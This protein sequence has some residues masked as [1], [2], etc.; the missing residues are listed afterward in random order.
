ML[1]SQKERDHYEEWVD[2]IKMKVR[3]IEWSG[4]LWLRIWKSGGLL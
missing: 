4:M 3:A 1:I 2:N